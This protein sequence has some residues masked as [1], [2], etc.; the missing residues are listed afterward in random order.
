MQIHN[1]KMAKRWNALLLLSVALML[2]LPETANADLGSGENGFF[3]VLCKISVWCALFF[4]QDGKNKTTT[5]A[6]F[7][8]GSGAASHYWL[9]IQLSY[10]LRW[11][12]PHHTGV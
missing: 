8:G 10:Y 3:G 9:A 5:S 2:L 12:V 7:C 1:N 4:L 11:V 6:A